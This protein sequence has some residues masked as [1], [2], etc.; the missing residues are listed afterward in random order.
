M[1]NRFALSLASLSLLTLGALAVPQIARAQDPPA[2]TETTA[3]EKLNF[4]VTLETKN[5]TLYDVLALLFKQAHAQ[6][7][8][9]IS[10]K[11]IA[12]PDL[13]ISKKALRIVLGIVLRGTNYTYKDEGGV[14]TVNLKVDAPADVPVT[15]EDKPATD[16]NRLRIFK[17]N[18]ANFNATYIVQ[19]LGGRVIPAGRGAQNGGQGGGGFGGGGLGQGGGGGFGGGG[20]GGGGLGGGGGGFG[21]GGGGFGGG[22]GGGFGGGG[23]GRGGGGGGRGGGGF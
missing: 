16:T 17:I 14:Y 1:A 22:G 4:P 9:D 11:Q 6:S 21:G 13:S 10:L 20:Q 23:G 12:A 19:L 2:D 3:G 18:P 7:A 8:L 15:A 5:A